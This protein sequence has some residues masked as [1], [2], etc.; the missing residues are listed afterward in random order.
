MIWP[1]NKNLKVSG[2]YLSDSTSTFSIKFYRCVGPS[3]C[4]SPSE[5]DNKIKDTQISILIYDWYVNFNDY[6]NPIKPYVDDVY[7]Y[8]LA[9]GFKKQLKLYVKLNEVELS[10]NYVLIDSPKNIILL[11]LIDSQLMCLQSHLMDKFLKWVCE[12]I[13][14]RM[15]TKE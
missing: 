5:I 14:I 6:E 13:K 12:W 9:P 10:D 3:I 15:Y 4:H 2:N 8:Q 11:M 1:Q 7:S